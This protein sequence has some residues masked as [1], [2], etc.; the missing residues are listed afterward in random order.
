MVVQIDPSKRSFA[1]VYA[2]PSNPVMAKRFEP[3][4]AVAGLRRGVRS[5]GSVCHDGV[6]LPVG[7]A[8][9]VAVEVAVGVL[10]G[11][12]VGVADG[13]PHVVGV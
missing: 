6:Q 13:V 8:V 9:A 5:G 3:T 2:V 4:T 12:F 1:V 10:V 11:V 7:V